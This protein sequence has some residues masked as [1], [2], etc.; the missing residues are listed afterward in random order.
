MIELSRGCLAKCHS[1][2]LQI[3]FS[4]SATKVVFEYGITIIDTVRSIFDSCVFCISIFVGDA[5]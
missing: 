3:D 2:H 4:K 1:S 5:F